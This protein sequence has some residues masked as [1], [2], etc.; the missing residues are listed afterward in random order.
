MAIKKAF[1]DVD[2]DSFGNVIDYVA[3]L[4][5]ERFNLYI[6]SKRKSRTLPQNRY[7]WGVV[8]HTISQDT[9]I[10]VED[11]HEYFKHKY[12]MRTQFYI[13]QDLM[14]VTADG[15]IS[16]ARGEIMGGLHEVSMSTKSMNTK[17]FGEYI[18]KIIRWASEQG[19]RIP[20]PNEIPEESLI[21]MIN[22]GY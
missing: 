10:D 17:E 19:M 13:S 12:T 20:Q 8:L 21:E 7:Y 22:Q 5:G 9:G 3:G 1:K 15:V 6:C 18:D 11:L 4:N 14:E 16:K 2:F